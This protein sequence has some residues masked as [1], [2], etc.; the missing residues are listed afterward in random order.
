[1]RSLAVGA[2]LAMGVAFGAAPA[3]AEYQPGEPPNIDPGTPVFAGSATPVPAEPAAQ[4]PTK[5]T[6]RAIYDADVAAGGTSYWFD[7]ILAR[8]FLSNGDSALF[9][10][11][12]ALYMYTHNPR[13]LGFGAGGTGANGGGGYAYRQPPT[14]AAPQ[15]LYTIAVTGA[16]LTED[17]T[18]QLQYP[19]YF[20]ATFTRP[21][22]SVAEKK[23]ITDNNVAVTDLMLTNTDTAALTTTV[24]A[25]SPIATTAVGGRHRAHRHRHRAVR[26]DHSVPAVQRRRVHGQRHEPEPHR[27]ARPRRVGEPEGADGCARQRAAELRDRLRPLPRRTTRTPPG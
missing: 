10:R 11:G 7:R 20:G 5:N 23:F 26:P 1:M 15:S 2:I 18:T 9:T 17:T 6:L 22:L 12:R 3:N 16:A 13:L 27:F 21:G 25:S 14:T 19:S 8:P 24:S 4:D